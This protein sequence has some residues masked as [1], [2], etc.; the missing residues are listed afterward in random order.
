MSFKLSQHVKIKR[1]DETGKVVEEYEGE[2][3]GME[4]GFRNK[5]LPDETCYYVDAKRH[6]DERGLLLKCPEPLRGVGIRCGFLIVPESLLS[7]WNQSA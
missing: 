2:I 6:R 5:S 1:A 4:D 7:A 3:V